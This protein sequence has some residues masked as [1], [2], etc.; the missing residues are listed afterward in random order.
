MMS[1]PLELALTRG[2]WR[3]IAFRASLVALQVVLHRRGQRQ[4]NRGGQ[5]FQYHPP[6]QADARGIGLHD[7]ARLDL[8]RT[9]GYQDP[10]AFDFDHA[11]TADIDR[12]QILQIA[13]CRDVNVLAPTGLEYGRPFWHPDRIP[14]DAQFDVASGATGRVPSHDASSGVKYLSWAMA[15]SMA[16]GAVCPRPQIEAS[17]MT[18]AMSARRA[19]S[20]W[21]E[22]SNWLSISR[23]SHSSWRTVPMRQGTH[24]PHDSSRKKAAI[25]DRTAF[26]SMVSSNTMMSPEPMVA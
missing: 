22:P 19:S 26:I 6:A 18:C 23:C 20:S 17:R 15:D 12:G 24:C 21:S 3:P 14:I 9:G 5:E 1:Y 16:L 7:H 11:D 25:R 4:I 2:L 13:Q 8:P 10:R